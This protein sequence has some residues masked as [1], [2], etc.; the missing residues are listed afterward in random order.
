MDQDGKG[1][2][3]SRRRKTGGLIDGSL[4]ATL[5][6]ARI[7]ASLRA[8]SVLRPFRSEVA[9]SRAPRK[10]GGRRAFSADPERRKVVAQTYDEEL[11]DVLGLGQ[12]P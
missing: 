9:S 1:G 10:L 5:S 7:L 3:R 6:G 4:N 2:L 8:R 12:A 11:E